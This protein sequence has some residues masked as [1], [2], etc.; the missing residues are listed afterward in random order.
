MIDNEYVI[1]GYR[2]GFSSKR[3]LARS[4]FMLHNE[5]VNVWTHLIGVFCFILLIGWTTIS[6][7]PS[8]I[9]SYMKG[10]PLRSYIG[11]PVPLQAEELMRENIF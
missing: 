7:V 6:F 1:H 11:A 10:F 9:M 5:S 2:I 4:L 3:K 8:P